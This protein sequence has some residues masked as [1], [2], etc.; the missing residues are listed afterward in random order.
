MSRWI[1][2][3][4]ITEETPWFMGCEVEHRNPP[5]LACKT[6]TMQI[7]RGCPISSWTKVFPLFLSLTPSKQKRAEKERRASLWSRGLKTNSRIPNMW[8]RTWV[9]ISQHSHVSIGTSTSSKWELEPVFLWTWNVFPRAS[10]LHN[11]S[12]TII[13]HHYTKRKGTHLLD[14]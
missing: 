9:K 8:V 12:G 11:P 1:E 4:W 5:W 2:A 10:N 3:S 6:F 7:W 14:N 13:N